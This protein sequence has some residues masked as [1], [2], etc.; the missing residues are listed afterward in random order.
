MRMEHSLA[1][2]I[3]TAA[4]AFWLAAEVILAVM[5]FVGLIVR[6]AGMPERTVR[7]RWLQHA[8]RRALSV[9]RLELQVAGT[10]PSSGL[11]VCN[12]LSYLDILVLGATAPSIF[13]SKDDVRRWPVFGWL[14]TL[15]GTLF[16]RRDKRLDVARMTEE[17]RRA[18]D[19]GVRVV[20][21][22]EGTTSDG[23]DVRP[24]KSALLEAATGQP[25]SLSVGF[26]EYTLREGSV[27]DEVCYW[28]DMIFAPHLLNLLGRRG[29]EARLRFTR[30]QQASA[31]RKQLARQ[32]HSEVV[33]LK[34]TCAV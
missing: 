20:L 11:L 19:A 27:A 7:A 2:S 15:A 30:L 10:I 24:F 14:A 3:R 26:I 13:I 31:D 9:F 5:R 34:Q 25:D 4:R 23:R 16:I 8:C 6:Q 17:V 29:L 22:P 1:R 32:L 18:L 33:R 12:H 21:F 28:R